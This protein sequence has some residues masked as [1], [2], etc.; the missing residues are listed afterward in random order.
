MRTLVTRM[1]PIGKASGQP[2]AYIWYKI[3]FGKRS[4]ASLC[5]AG[6]TGRARA[7]N[8]M[9]SSDAMRHAGAQNK[10]GP[11]HTVVFGEYLA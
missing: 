10:R 5:Y 6:L 1:D 2:V 4:V 7:R 8:L 9:R 11:P 3:Y